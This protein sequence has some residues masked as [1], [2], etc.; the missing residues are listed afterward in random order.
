MIPTKRLHNNEQKA[1]GMHNKLHALGF[2]I[3]TYYKFY[4]YSYDSN[5]IFEIQKLEEELFCV[6][7]QM[8]WNDLF[9]KL[10]TFLD[11]K[12][13]WD[14]Y[15]AEPPNHICFDAA[16]NF[17]DQLKNSDFKPSRIAPSAVNGI[18]ISFYNQDKHIYVEFYN[19][20]LPYFLMSN[21]KEDHTEVEELNNIEEQIEKMRTFLNGD[22]D[23]K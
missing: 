20:G 16:K 4:S 21:E 9:N 17:L 10:N 19:N 7:E 18:G 5:L 23:A 14:S 13:N 11:L 15:G 2:R 12:P 6:M 22:N 8:S 3:S 1:K